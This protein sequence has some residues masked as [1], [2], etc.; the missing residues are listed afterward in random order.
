MSK[1]KTLILGA[2]PK[3]QRYA[4]LAANKL[5]EHG[6]EIVQIGNRVGEA[7]G[8]KILDEPVPLEGIDTVT[9]YL[10]PPN[11]KV[12]YDYIISLKPKRVIFNPGT[13]N[14]ELIE[15]LEENSIDYEDACTLVMLSAG[16]Y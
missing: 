3:P 7:A 1:K 16:T 5:K 2:S 11:Q 14:E 4:F 12:Y 8:E 10:G 6:H 15:K 13:W 9:L